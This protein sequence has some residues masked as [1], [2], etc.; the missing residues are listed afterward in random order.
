MP[1]VNYFGLR[2]D[3]TILKTFLVDY[4]KNLKQLTLLE[5]ASFTQNVYSAQDLT[6]IKYT[7]GFVAEVVS[8]RSQQETTFCI[9][10]IWLNSFKFTTYLET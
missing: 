9:Q 7:P 6:G 5:R 4:R 2:S 1:S 3:E 10:H 8:A